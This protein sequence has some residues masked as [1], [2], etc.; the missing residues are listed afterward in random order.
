MKKLNINGKDISL[1]LSNYRSMPMAAKLS[2]IDNNGEE[3]T[4]S[5]CL[6]E[7]IRLDDPMPKGTIWLDDVKQP[8]AVKT[9]KENGIISPYING[10]DPLSY[11]GTDGFYTLYKIDMDKMIDYD[12]EGTKTYSASYDTGRKIFDIE[13]MDQ[14]EYDAKYNNY[15]GPYDG[16]T[17][18]E[19][20]RMNEEYAERNTPENIE[21]DAQFHSF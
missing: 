3:N 15:P 14:E 9:L 21:W 7:T 2:T 13:S 18:E 20:D 5:L 1:K 8:N 10:R 17:P 19:Y 6:G 4:I 11:H 16:M 12:P